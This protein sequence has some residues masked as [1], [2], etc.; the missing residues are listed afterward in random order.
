[1]GTKSAARHYRW[2]DV[3]QDEPMTGFL[4]RFL[5][6]DRGM[7]ARLDITKGA[8]VQRHSHDAEQ[9]TFVVSGALRLKLGESG[10]EVVDVRAGEVLVIP[11]NVPH[12]AE[13]LEDT[14]DMDFFSPP[15]QDWIDKT[16][17]YL[18]QPAAKR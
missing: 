5:W 14:L 18:R 3:A 9:I 16:D 2:R 12:G 15:R 8:V 10:E 17:A 7:L 4:R 11:S 6:G 13:A 1:M